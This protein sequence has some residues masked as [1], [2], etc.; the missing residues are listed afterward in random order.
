MKRVVEEVLEEVITP[1]IY[2]EALDLIRD[3]RS[4]GRL[5]CI[6]SSSPEEIVAPM[7]VLV[8]ADRHIATL[9][10]IE[11]GHYTGE[12]E[13]Y[14]YGQAKADAIRELAETEGIDLT[15]SFAYS[16][17]A[18]DLPMLETV[19]N[20]VAVNADKPLRRVAVERGWRLEQFRNPV[21]VRDRL[22][23]LQRPDITLDERSGAALAVAGTA[24][25]A[26]WLFRRGR[27]RPEV[28][29]A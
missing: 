7:A 6:V 19:G 27:R 18:T 26:W 24:M 28:R 8:Q 9:P 14:A 5:I 23:Q 25:F 10:R 12:L 13:F 22:P 3:H 29:E 4:A 15:G 16:D 1:L 2:A 17:S 20:P 11:D 21:S